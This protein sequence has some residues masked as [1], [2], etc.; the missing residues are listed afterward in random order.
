MFRAGHSGNP[1]GRPKGSISP[2][3][4]A[5]RE[6]FQPYKEDIKEVF[7][8]ALHEAKNSKP[9]AIKLI[10]EYFIG[11]QTDLDAEAIDDLLQER[12]RQLAPE[13]INEARQKAYEAL[14]AGNAP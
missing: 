10:F 3:S 1:N 11:K 9:W 6:L 14:N 2:A 5:R 4:F 13:I 8:K 12:L 7:L